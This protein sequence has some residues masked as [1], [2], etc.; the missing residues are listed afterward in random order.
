MA[1]LDPSSPLLNSQTGLDRR[2]FVL[3]Q[4]LRL[5]HVFDCVE[6]VAFFYRKALSRRLLTRRYLSTDME[7]SVLESLGLHAHPTLT[8]YSKMVQDVTQSETLFGDFKARPPLGPHN[9]RPRFLL[10]KIS[11]LSPDL[12]TIAASCLRPHPWSCA[13]ERV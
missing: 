9:P 6:E 13:T 11:L 12:L 1:G 4:T 7:Q 8:L 2:P 3:S 10:L 5:I